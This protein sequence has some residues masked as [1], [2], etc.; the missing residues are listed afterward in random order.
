MLHPG[1]RGLDLGYIFTRIFAR[2]SRALDSSIVET[3]DLNNPGHD[4]RMMLASFMQGRA[5]YPDEAH[6]Q[7]FTDE[8]LMH[9]KDMDVSICACQHE[10]PKHEMHSMH[11]LQT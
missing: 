3:L 9:H 7:S 10:N 11:V 6:L 1:T 4:R 2:A 8:T 5:R